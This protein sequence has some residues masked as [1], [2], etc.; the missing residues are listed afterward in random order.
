MDG[1]IDTTTTTILPRLHTKPTHHQQDNSI[2][3]RSSTIPTVRSILSTLS[4]RLHVHTRCLPGLWLAHF[5]LLSNTKIVYNPF[6]M[7]IYTLYGDMR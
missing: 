5:Y 1:L 4:Q 2:S 6:T 7:Q 3:Q